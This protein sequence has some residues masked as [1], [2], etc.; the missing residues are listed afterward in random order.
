MFESQRTYETFRRFLLTV[1]N[2]DFLIFLFF[3]ALSSMFWLI[4]TLNETYEKD[5]DVPLQ[6][7][8]VPKNVVLTT[9]LEDTVRVTVSDKGYMLM[10]Y[11]YGDVIRP[12]TLN[13]GSYANQQTGKGTVPVADFYKHLY[14]QL[15]SSSK[16]TSVKPERL[17]FYFNHGQSKRVPVK[18]A[19]RVEPGKSFYLARTLFWPDSVTIYAG[20]HMIDSIKAAYTEELDIVNLQDTVIREVSLQKLR[21]VKTVPEKV[22]I[23]LYPD[24]LIDESMEVPIVAVNMPEGR[25]LRTFPARVKVHFT[26][27]VRTFRQIRPSQFRVEVDY[28]ELSAKPSE[29]CE[30]HLRTY[31]HAVLKAWLELTNV[32]YLIE[33][34]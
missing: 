8:N 21:G 9:P 4:L 6:M 15:Y 26:C 34:Q 14:T 33:Q 3:L 28:Q 12:V 7:T 29:K 27:G 24:V 22:R 31:P 25:V 32:D 18:L 2:K 1:V 17:E 11:M 20:K 19:G 16:I 30:L 10:T 5:I 13:F 23:G